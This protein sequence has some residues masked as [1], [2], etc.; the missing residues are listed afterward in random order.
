LGVQTV[1]FADKKQENPLDRLLTTKAILKTHIRGILKKIKILFA[2][3]KS[4]WYT[5]GTLQKSKKEKS[6]CRKNPKT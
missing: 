2:F 6:E 3:F 1:S 5:L 4:I